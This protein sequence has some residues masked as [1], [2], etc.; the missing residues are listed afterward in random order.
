MRSS[1]ISRFIVLLLIGVIHAWGDLGHRTVAKVAYKFLSPA[2]KQYLD[3]ILAY[4]DNRDISDAAVWPDQI[5]YFRPYT[6]P[7]HY[8]GNSFSLTRFSQRLQLQMLKI[9]HHRVAW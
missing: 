8:I 3:G 5:K 7:W 6:A 4:G 1:T 2:T 9:L